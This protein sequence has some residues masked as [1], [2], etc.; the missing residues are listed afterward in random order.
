[1]ERSRMQT[2]LKTVVRQLLLVV[3]LCAFLYP[4]QAAAQSS[5]GLAAADTSSP[6]ATLESF[7]DACNELDERIQVERFQDRANPTYRLLTRR[8]RDCLDTSGLARYAHEQRALEVAVCLKEILDRDELPP[9]DEIPDTAAIEAADD[10]GEFARWRIPGT[11]LTI[12]RINEGPEK[13]EYLISAG[14]VDRAVNYFRD[15]E[16]RPYRTTGP[17]TSPGLHRWYMSAPGH[18]LIGAIVQRLPDRIRFGRSLG[19]A[20]RKWRGIA[21]RLLV[22]LALMVVI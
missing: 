1:M 3:T 19:R 18:P 4:G 14:T 13:H 15:V 21:N 6:R 8:I 11:R 17:D 9:W 20:N 5:A 12:A 7:I 10:P 16:A 22:A 2:A